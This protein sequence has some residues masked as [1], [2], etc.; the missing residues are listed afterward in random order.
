MPYSIFFTRAGHA[1]HG[2]YAIRRLGRPA[3]HGCVRLA[4]K[5][6]AQ[7][8][9]LVR[10]HGLANTQVVIEGALPSALPRIAVPLPRERRTAL[11]EI[12][13][14]ETPAVTAAKPIAVIAVHQPEVSAQEH[15]A[16]ATLP[17]EHRANRQALP[18]PETSI[19]AA[20]AAPSDTKP[21][22]DPAIVA[23]PTPETP[24]Q[25]HRAFA[26]IVPLPRERR[27][28][29]RA[30]TEPEAPVAAE[31][32]TP[33]VAKPEPGQSLF[34]AQPPET[35]VEESR[36]VARIA[37]LQRLRRAEL[38]ALT[39]PEAPVVAERE[40]PAIA[41]AEP[42][43]VVV[44]NHALETQAEERHVSAYAV[45]L[46]REL[47]AERRALPEPEAPVV[48][49]RE[50]QAT[51]DAKPDKTMVAARMPETPET[52]ALLPALSLCRPS[53]APQRR[54]RLNR[55]S[56]KWHVNMRCNRHSVHSPSPRLYLS[57]RHDGARRAHTTSH[58]SIAAH[59]RTIGRRSTG[60]AA[61]ALRRASTTTHGWRSSRSSTS[62]AIGCGA[63]TI[64]GPGRGISM[65]GDSRNHPPRA[66]CR[67]RSL[68]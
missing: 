17:P 37:P 16:F 13:K 31:R 64:G 3:S 28:E 66:A 29:M 27:T 43:P 63:T 40:T 32:E 55:C 48:T 39:E 22:S 59:D 15:R 53:A 36:T 44:A 25:Q 47:R 18:E 56:D 65:I 62:T 49:E 57:R 1:I 14:L 68:I 10:K 33:A 35:P 21:E 8:F 11:L 61:R 67:Y 6:A 58:R 54:R 52:S 20:H 41:N 23:A 2:S 45:P 5:N 9:A 26:R 51:S 7:L 19:I 60:T 12:A 42:G 4:P 24:A 34:T 38:R 30:L 50:V 46:P